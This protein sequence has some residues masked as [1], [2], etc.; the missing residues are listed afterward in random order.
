M[1]HPVLPMWFQYTDDEVLVPRSKAAAAEAFVIGEY[2]R[3]GEVEERSEVSHNHQ[4]AWLKTAWESLPDHLVPLYPSPEFLRKKA[5]IATGH[6]TVQ[7]YPCGSKVEAERWAAN[8]KRESDAYTIVETSGTVV[9]VFRARSQARG[10][11]D[12][13]E[14]Q[15]VKQDLIEWVSAL[16]GV[17]PEDLARAA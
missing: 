10:K 11:M 9:R 17:A 13:A 15:K 5:L 1:S 8:L 7:D 14:F 3:M 4:F 6:C 16:I 12:K 2:Y